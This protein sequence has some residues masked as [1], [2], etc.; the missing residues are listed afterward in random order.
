MTKK[1]PPPPFHPSFLP[2]FLPSSKG[3][4]LAAETLTHSDGIMTRKAKEKVCS[5]L[6]K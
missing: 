3:L 1:N 5:G 4:F 6:K 2:S